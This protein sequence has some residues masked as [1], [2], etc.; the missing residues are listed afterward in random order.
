VVGRA[1]TVVHATNNHE[2]SDHMP[3]IVMTFLV[4]ITEPSSNS[5]CQQWN[6]R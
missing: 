3:E 1:W 5:L 6:N 2:I 4:K